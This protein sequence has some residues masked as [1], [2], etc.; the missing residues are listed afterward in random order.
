MPIL[1][2]LPF[3]VDSSGFARGASRG[4]SPDVFQRVQNLWTYG[5]QV[6]DWITVQVSPWK[7][8]PSSYELTHGF[9]RPLDG[10]R[11]WVLEASDSHSGPWT[12]LSEHKDDTHLGHAAFDAHRWEIQGCDKFYQI[13]RIRSTGPNAS[14]V[15]GNALQ[16]C[17]CKMEL[18]GRLRKGSNEHD[19][20]FERKVVHQTSHD[21][22]PESDD[23]EEEEDEDEE[24]EEEDEDEDE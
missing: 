21:P 3:R 14:T 7:I 23:D 11:N 15:D 4:S 24:D 22:L 13:F 8:C 9:R 20:V 10:M 17:V 6:G 5:H 2:H 12:V 1:A 19:V 18:W 16:M